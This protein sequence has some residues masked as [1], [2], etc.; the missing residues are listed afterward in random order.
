MA[1]SSCCLPSHPA[2]Q[3]A[4]KLSTCKER[5]SLLKLSPAQRWSLETRFTPGTA[6]PVHTTHLC[7][8]VGL[9]TG[10]PW[11]RT[12]KGTKPKTSHK[13]S[14]KIRQNSKQQWCKQYDAFLKGEVRVGGPRL[15]CAV[16][17]QAPR[18]LFCCAAYRS[19]DSNGGPASL[20]SSRHTGRTGIRI[21]SSD[22]LPTS[23]S[24]H[25]CS[26]LIG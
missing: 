26:R 12:P 15:V 25:V 21:L 9:L 20:R 10:T 6:P 18:I 7:R 16:R 24:G 22:T 2:P 8:S 23:C 4:V 14:K 3:E 17:G 19:R 5:I 13:L 1:D 11:T